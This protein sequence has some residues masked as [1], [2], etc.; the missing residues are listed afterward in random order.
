MRHDP[1]VEES[2]HRVSVGEPRGEHMAAQLPAR[3]S[4]KHGHGQAR[5]LSAL[6]IPAIFGRAVRWKS[7]QAEDT[8]FTLRYV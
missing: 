3:N 5:L 4:E 6:T 2:Y 1:G 7:R 8:V